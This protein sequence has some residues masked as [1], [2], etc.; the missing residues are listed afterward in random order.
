MIRFLFSLILISC[1]DATKNG[2]GDINVDE[3]SLNVQDGDGDSSDPY[4]DNSE[5][6]NV[7]NEMDPSA[8]DELSVEYPGLVGATSYFAGSYIRGTDGWYGREKWILYPNEE[9]QA[10]AYTQW[11]DGDESLS[12]IA[13]GYPCEISWDMYVQEV[14]ELETC[15]ACDLGLAVQAEISFSSTNC[16]QGLWSEPS[17]Q[18]WQNVYEIAKANGNSIFYFQSNGAPFGWGYS[19]DDAL[20]F[21]SEPNCKWF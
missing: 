8:C 12:N 19:S 18:S 11:M 6:P 1:S 21:L 15:F 2:N 3:E 10:L 9:W 14:D 16:P 17:E 20:N 5:I 4:F 7:L 13:Q